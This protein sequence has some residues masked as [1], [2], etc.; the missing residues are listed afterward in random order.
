MGIWLHWSLARRADI[1]FMINGFSPELACPGAGFVAIETY[2][3]KSLVTF[4]LLVLSSWTPKWPKLARQLLKP[5]SY[6]TLLGCSLSELYPSLPRKIMR[7]KGRRTGK[8]SMTGK[9]T[10]CNIM[11]P[12]EQSKWE[13]KV[14]KPNNPMRMLSEPNWPMTVQ[15]ADNVTKHRTERWKSPQNQHLSIPPHHLEVVNTDE[16]TFYNKRSVA[17][18]ACLKKETQ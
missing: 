4:V 18:G 16:V 12:I 10:G 15:G 7:E 17:E 5:A 9:L 6:D 11:G 14:P 1:S 2:L 13:F 8:E 3:A